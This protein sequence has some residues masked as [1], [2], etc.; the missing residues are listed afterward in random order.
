MSNSKDSLIEAACMPDMRFVIAVKWHP[1]LMFKN[2]T[3]EMKLLS[4][5][6]SA[7]G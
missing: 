2:D 4:A 3:D 5:F 6:V 7:C 1:E